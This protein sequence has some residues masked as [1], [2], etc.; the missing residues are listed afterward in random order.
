[1]AKSM[2]GFG[3]AT[4]GEG[5]DKAFSIEI[6]SVNH[7]YLDINTRMPKSM[8]SLEEK[9]RRKIKESLNRGKVDLFINYK[10]YAKA[11]SVAKVNID[12]AKTYV[13]ALTNLRNE[14]P[15]I[16]DDL[17][18]SLISKHP[19]V[20]II[21]E[22]EESLDAI[23]SEIEPLL[24]E[25][26]DGLLAM[27]IFEGT[28]L[29]ED[30]ISKTIEI[31]KLVAFIEGKADILVANYKL[32]LEDRLK[33]L[34]NTINVDENRLAMEVAVFADKAAIDEEITRLKSHIVHLRET[35]SISEPMGRKL[36]FIMQEMNREANTIASKSTD[37]NITNKVID[38]K[39][40]L[41]KIREQ[42]QNIE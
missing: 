39:N 40:L 28:K 15:N 30:I 9:M 23:W 21:E 37:L 14:F 31:E 2:T 36:D 25:S 19:D 4:A 5:R 11:D 42:V 13:E 41:E 8:F 1:M 12:F 18:L 22:K 38:I 32:K 35:L 33:E 24:E 26:L 3:R 16:K 10:N 17:S 34:L 27:R 20:I 6:K 29:K 7:R